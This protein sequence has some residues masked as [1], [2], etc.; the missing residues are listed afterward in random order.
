M[1]IALFRVDERLIHGQVTVGWGSALDPRRYLV[2]DDE[3]ARS[4]WEAELYRFGTPES[5]TAEFLSVT[6]ARSRLSALEAAPEVTILLTRSLPSMA[7]LARGGT[8]AGREVNLGGLHSAPGRREVLPYVHLDDEGRSSI[9]ELV[10]R[11]VRVTARD[12]PSTPRVGSDR[13]LGSHSR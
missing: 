5:A 8:L 9:R 1:P 10:A 7:E 11:G 12:L 2:V 3:L 4:D 13:L 6:E